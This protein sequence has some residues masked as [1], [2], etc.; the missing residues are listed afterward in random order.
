MMTA[1]GSSRSRSSCSRP[2]FCAAAASN[3]VVFTEA[4]ACLKRAAT[5]GLRPA[6]RDGTALTMSSSLAASVTRCLK[7]SKESQPT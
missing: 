5:K 3:D 4:Q 2:R 6:A 1:S 7:S